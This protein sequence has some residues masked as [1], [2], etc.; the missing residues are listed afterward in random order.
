MATGAREAR[1]AMGAAPHRHSARVVG[2]GAAGL[3]PR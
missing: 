3:C 2:L 1:P